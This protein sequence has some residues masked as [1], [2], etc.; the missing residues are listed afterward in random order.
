MKAFSKEELAKNNGEN[1]APVFIAYRG[2]VYDVT[3]SPLWGN[4]AHQG[5]HEAGK[6]LADD[7]ESM[8]PH[9]TEVLGRYPK[10]GILRSP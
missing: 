1:G 4:G 3:G 8:A 6:D 5:M 2:E 10:I 7:L 9:G